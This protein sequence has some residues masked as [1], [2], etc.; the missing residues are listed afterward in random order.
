MILVVSD[1]QI[2]ER[3]THEALMAQK[4]AYYELYTRQFEEDATRRT[5]DRE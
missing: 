5:L 2:I 3:G 4:G 1:G